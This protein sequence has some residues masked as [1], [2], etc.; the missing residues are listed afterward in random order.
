MEHG[1]HGYV[2]EPEGKSDFTVPSF[3]G[4]QLLAMNPGKFSGKHSDIKLSKLDENIP[5]FPQQRYGGF[6]SHRGT[7]SDYLCY[8]P[9]YV[10]IFQEIN[11]PTIGVSYLH[12]HVGF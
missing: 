1:F 5:T 11:H 4:Y 2:K 3:W 10:R 6:L 9:L 12:D 8:V 7:P